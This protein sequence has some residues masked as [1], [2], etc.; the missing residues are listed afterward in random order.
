[1]IKMLSLSQQSFCP[2]KIKSFYTFLPKPL[3]AIKITCPSLPDKKDVEKKL[4]G[5]VKTKN[6]DT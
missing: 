2:V 6:W 3:L 5:T 4:P 1:M